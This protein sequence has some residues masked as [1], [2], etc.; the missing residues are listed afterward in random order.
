MIRSLTLVALIIG[1]I[2]ILLSAFVLSAWL[3]VSAKKVIKPVLALLSIAF[4][5]LGFWNFFQNNYVLSSVASFFAMVC[6]I[7][8]MFKPLSETWKICNN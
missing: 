3:K 2:E 5:N 6:L 8:F 7:F 1:L 4:L